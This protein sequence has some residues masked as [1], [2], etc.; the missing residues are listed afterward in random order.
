MHTSSL[1]TGFAIVGG[2][3][4]G[5]L[6]QR[7]WRLSHVMMLGVKVKSSSGDDGTFLCAEGACGDEEVFAVGAVCYVHHIEAYRIVPV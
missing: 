3:G 7:C 4:G 6:C 1:A 5:G 2:L